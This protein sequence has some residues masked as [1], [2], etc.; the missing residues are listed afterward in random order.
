MLL[1][2]DVAGIVAISNNSKINACYNSGNIESTNKV[3]S[4][5]GVDR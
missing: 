3:P 5:F 1:K 2:V 4:P